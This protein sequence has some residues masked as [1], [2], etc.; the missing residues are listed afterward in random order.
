MINKLIENYIN[1]MNINDVDM[2]AKENGVI[3][4]QEELNIIY[5]TIKQN[6]QTIIY[7]DYTSV[8]N[9]VKYK[10]SPSTYKKAEELFFYFKNKYQKLL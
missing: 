10:L 8:F 3:L 2:F 1:R 6:W 9:N 7:G 4:K 5:E